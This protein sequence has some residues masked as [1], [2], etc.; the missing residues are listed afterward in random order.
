M[1]DS[2]HSSHS[3]VVP[4]IV[5]TVIGVVALIAGIIMLVLVHRRRPS[6]PRPVRLYSTHER[7]RSAN[8]AAASVWDNNVQ[9]DVALEKT[10]EGL[11]EM[12][13]ELAGE[14]DFLRAQDHAYSGSGSGSADGVSPQAPPPAGKGSRSSKR[15]R[16]AKKKTRSSTSPA[17]ASPGFNTEDFMVQVVATSPVHP[18]AQELDSD[19]VQVDLDGG[20][21]TSPSPLL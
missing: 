12:D 8:G 20:T 17:T 15:V 21:H 9:V 18:L 6:V 14:A 13:A 16:V 7:E 4:I 5:P 19:D 10:T 1:S 2:G 3:S 11:D